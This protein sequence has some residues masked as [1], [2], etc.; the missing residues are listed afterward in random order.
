MTREPPD[1]PAQGRERIW[2]YSGSILPALNRLHSGSPGPHASGL[3]GFRMRTSG[4]PNL[5][6]KRVIH[7][8]RGPGRTLAAGPISEQ[9]AGLGY[10]LGEPTAGQFEI[11]GVDVVPY[12]P[13]P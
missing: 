9:S 7:L 2:I 4:N 10:G 1:V 8:R 11:A 12:A 3:I 13:T 6:G 5:K